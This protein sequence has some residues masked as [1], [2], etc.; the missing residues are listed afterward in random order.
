MSRT[1]CAK[2][3]ASSYPTRSRNERLTT[4]KEP[5]RSARAI[6]IEADAITVRTRSSAAVRLRAL[7]AAFLASVMS[8]AIADVPTTLPSGSQI[9]A[10]VS[11]TGIQVQGAGA[12]V[13]GHPRFEADPALIRDHGGNVYGSGQCRLATVDVGC[14]WGIRT[15]VVAGQALSLVTGLQPWDCKSIAKASNV[16]ILHLPPR[17]EGPLT[18]GNAGCRPFRVVRL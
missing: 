14:L 18:C 17:A 6:P 16:R 11:E 5:S 1:R 13:G 8:R 2:N 4:R 3:H 7:W 15:E 12:A 10:M 9:G